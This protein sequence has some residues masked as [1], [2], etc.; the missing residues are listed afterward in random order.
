LVSN[1]GK[2]GEKHFGKSEGQELRIENAGLHRGGRGGGWKKT[3][4]I[5]IGTNR[6]EP[7][8]RETSGVGGNNPNQKQLGRE[9]VPT[10]TLVD[11]SQHN[12][13]SSIDTRRRAEIDSIPVLSAKLGAEGNFEDNPNLNCALNERKP[14]RNTDLGKSI[15]FFI[16]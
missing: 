6:T 12:T 9:T 3:D 1:H 4:D 15:P 13:E 8:A 16:D 11:S 2:V 7:W 10:V 5:A 14:E